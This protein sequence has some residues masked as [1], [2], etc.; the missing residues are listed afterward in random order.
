MKKIT[1]ILLAFLML[2]SAIVS[3]VACNDDTQK[4]TEGETILETEA[5]T[6]SETEEE[7]EEQTESE[8]IAEVLEEIKENHLPNAKKARVLYYRPDYA[9]MSEKALGT[10]LQGLAA[11]HSD[12]QI[13]TKTD[14]LS[15]IAPY[16]ESIWGVTFAETLNGESYTLQSLTEHYVAMGFI[17]GYIL[18]A[19]DNHET[20]NVGV[21]L[22]GVLD[23]LLATAETEQMLKDMGLTCLI[24]VTD[25]NDAW[26]RQS[27]YWD[28]INKDVSFEQ[29]AGMME[30]LGDYAI[31]C[32][33]YYNYYDGLVPEEHMA[34]YEFLNDNAIVFGWNNTIGEFGAVNT[35]G[36]IN[37]CM[38]PSDFCNSLSTYSGFDIESLDQK[39][40][41][42]SPADKE[43]VHTVAFLMTDGDNLQWLMNTFTHG[44]NWYASPLRGSFD[45]SW[46]LPATAIEMN[47]PLVQYL[48]DSMTDRDEFIM[49]LSGIGYTFVSHFSEEARKEMTAEL[50]TY[51]ERADLRYAQI[52]D[53]GGWKKEIFADFTEHDAIEG[54]LYID[55][56]HYDGMNGS[57]MWT[58]GKPTVAA[59][60]AY[61]GSM[62]EP[63]FEH[64]ITKVNKA[65]TNPSKR[66]AY[67]LIT[68]HCWSS[69]LNEVNGL[70][71]AFDEDVDVVT[72]SEFMDRI[73]HNL[74]SDR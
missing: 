19:D 64:V 25:K 60:Y 71:E 66:N 55:Y 29:S 49:S 41:D 16:M 67:S 37:V 65:S 33:S 30:T 47:A 8:T 45:M 13:I 21:S 63:Y 43:N 42:N 32:G 59:R 3:L 2:L 69:G 39:R 5:D 31:L 70:I 1:A 50:A 10:S 46:G 7:T 38:V 73:I 57:I 4:E 74:G 20:Y 61:S 15:Q 44:T 28:L 23:A 51:M 56:V 40:N 52:L 27:E 9:T 14:T 18:C 24:D 48:Y 35:F 53:N 62:E 17:K 12:E 34:M 54:L 36:Q 6:E 26:L 68:V 72:V 22:A 11:K 58:N